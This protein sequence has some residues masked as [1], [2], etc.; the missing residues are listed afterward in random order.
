MSDNGTQTGIAKKIDD[1]ATGNL[2]SSG[3]A[4]LKAG[5]LVEAEALFGRA[6]AVDPGNAHIL[7]LR[8]TVFAQT[9]RTEA[10]IADM[11]TALQQ[12]PNHP[13]LLNNLGNALLEQGRLDEAVVHYR[14]ALQVKPNYPEALNNLGLALRALGQ[15]D[16][17]AASYT[18]AL[19]LRPNYADAL[20]NLGNV[21]KALGRPKE[22][23][24]RYRQVLQLAPDHVG[25]HWGEGLTRL[26]LGDFAAGWPKYEWRWRKK[27]HG[28]TQP[29]W[30]GSDFPDRALLIHC[31]QSLGDSIQFIRYTELVKQRGG[32]LV[33]IC[34]P[35]LERLFR[36]IADTDRL[37]TNPSDLPPCDYQISLL[38]LPLI[39]RTT[40]ATIP[41]RIPYLSAPPER[42]A[43]WRTCLQRLPGCKVGIVWRGRPSHQNDH[44]RSIAANLFA[45]LLD[46]KSCSFVSLQI[47]TLSEERE[48]FAGHGNFLDVSGDL[49]DFAETAAVVANLDLVIAVDTAVVHLAGA[50]GRPAWVLLPF[51]PDW[52]WLLERDDSPWYPTLRL[53]RQPAIGDWVSV[54]SMVQQQLDSIWRSGSIDR[55][56]KSAKT[57]RQFMMAGFAHHQAGRFGEAENLYINARA[58]NPGD[59]QIRYLYGSLLLQ[60]GRIDAAVDELGGALTL[61]PEY[62]DAMLNLGTAFLKRGQ[63]AEAVA[64]YQE[65]LRRRPDW[66]EVLNNLGLAL[67]DQGRLAEA[68]DC[69]EQALQLLPDNLEMLSNLGL[70]LIDAGNSGK[71]IGRF[72]EALRL[73][74]DVP[75]LLSSLGNALQAQGQLDEAVSCH[76]EALRLK[77]D[78]SLAFN[79]LACVLQKQG[80]LDEAIDQYGEALRI[81]P[82]DF[83]I[84]NNLGT[85][86]QAQGQLDEAVANYGEALR[87]KPND[88]QILNNLGTALQAQCKVKEAIVHFRQALRLRPDH[89]ETNWNYSLTCLLLGDFE[90]GWTKYEWR[91]LTKGSKPHGH[92][93]PQWNGSELKNRTILVH[94]EQGF[95]DSIQFVRY[96]EWVKAQGGKV[97]LFCPTELTRL[98]KTA[99]SIDVLASELKDLPRC[100][101][102]IPLLSLPLIFKTGLAT[103]PNRVPYLSA[104]PDLVVRWR[105]RLGGLPGCKVGIAWRGRPS[106]QNDHNR[107]IAANLFARLLDVKSCSFVSLQI[108]TL[109]EERET[110][111]GHGNFLDV[112]GDLSDFA[113]TAA[114]VANLDLVIAVDT[115]VIHLAGALGRPAWVL[116]PFAPDWRWL[117]E[118]DDSPWYPT[119]RLF[120]QPAIGDWV[121]VISVVQQQLIAKK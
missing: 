23:L 59:A 62:A 70:A 26:S 36:S 10:A 20:S 90:L 76:T 60:G 13:S 121:S 66:P 73:W 87:I 17:A 22:A 1:Q 83:Q 46:V 47:D 32:T 74:P 109:S 64:R 97:A 85:A 11:S 98:F 40:L 99:A 102:Q 117:L 104:F 16:E 8:G 29:Q 65:A 51:A 67:R 82:D 55:S 68:I 108:D 106:H 89:P 120:R 101:V 38:T 15:L 2:V 116:L 3:L 56:V 79:H 86:L 25:A 113:E 24:A 43:Y 61:D 12:S 57:A 4:C 84:L 28:F 35:V 95:G 63:L 44:N 27:P 7:F 19:H 31:E 88:F 72:K 77:P 52:R 119:L 118:R 14:H 110:F 18:Q 71:A 21:L 42:V 93:Q 39:F 50:L 92:P 6:L 96:A 100:E 105:I 114:V 34:P 112:S 69:F 53:F 111:A 78:C 9:G 107:S 115:A 48:T 103:I 49:S 58:A 41:K 94:C 75:E 5:K 81:K 80:K 91:W 37:I 54:I 30:D 33:V 45:R